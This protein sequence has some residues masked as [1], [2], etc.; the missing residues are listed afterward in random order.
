MIG[1]REATWLDL[2]DSMFAAVNA[3]ERHGPGSAEAIEAGRVE[4]ETQEAYQRAQAR[5]AEPGWDRTAFERWME[6]ELADPEA[7]L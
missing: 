5:E 6:A 1:P 2:K 3:A 7:G 4:T